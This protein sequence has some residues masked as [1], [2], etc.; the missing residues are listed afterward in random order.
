MERQ[1][2]KSENPTKD[3]SRQLIGTLPG[4]SWSRKKAVKKSK[5][6]FPRQVMDLNRSPRR[7]FKPGKRK[8]QALG[9]AKQ[10]KD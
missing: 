1:G 8:I 10:E 2:K 4:A 5:T 9:F 7:G 6:F 3:P